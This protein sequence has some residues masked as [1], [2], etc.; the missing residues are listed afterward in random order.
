MIG[1][2]VGEAGLAALEGGLPALIERYAADFVVVNGENAAEGY[3]IHAADYRRIVAAGA[4]AVTSGNHVW[5]KEDFI[6]LLDEKAVLRPANYPPSAP[7]HGYVVLEKADKCNVLHRLLV[8][9]LQGREYMAAI[10][11]PF[12][13]ADAV[14]SMSGTEQPVSGTALPLPVV[15][16]FHAE[17]TAEKEALGFYLDGR[18]AAL[19]GT[20]THVQTADERL[21][22]QGSA[23]ITDL[24][25]TGP[26]DSVIGMDIGVCLDRA[27]AQVFY[28]MKC[29]EGAAAIQGVVVEIDESRNKTLSIARI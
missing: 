23:Y 22:P 13:T 21:L 8:I 4:D 26:T 25:M 29:A 16:D 3:G 1:D 11:C 27:K 24:G 10:D 5:E 28:K 20:H 9:N 2:V 18:V 14:L 7:G 12:R 6:P 15:V 19:V 17:S